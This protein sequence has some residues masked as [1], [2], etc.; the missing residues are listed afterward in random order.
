MDF[1]CG[2]GFLLLKI[3][4]VFPDSNLIGVDKSEVGI[5]LAGERGVNA[6]YY[7]CDLLDNKLTFDNSFESDVGICCEVIEHISD[8]EIFLR[9]CC[10]FIKKGGCL[11]VS[12][13]GGS[14][15]VYDKHIG[16]LRHYTIK[17]LNELMNTVCDDVNINGMMFPFYNIYRFLRA[18]RGEKLIVDAKKQG[19]NEPTLLLRFVSLF[20]RFGI[21]YFSMDS[22]FGLNLIGVG[23]VKELDKNINIK[24]HVA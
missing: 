12:V 5:K 4:K 7:V 17:T 22:K 20:L 13:P 24:P 1:G 23:T 18:L 10:K 14:R 21:R 19:R 16:H 2:T 6:K 9:N 15:C 8:P 3:S 11:I